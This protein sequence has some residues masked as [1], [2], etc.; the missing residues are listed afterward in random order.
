MSKKTSRLEPEPIHCWVMLTTIFCIG[1]VL[2]IVHLNI[3]SEDVRDV[4]EVVD[5]FISEGES[6][7]LTTT[8]KFKNDELVQQSGLYQ[9]AHYVVF[10]D[11]KGEKYPAD[12]PKSFYNGIKE[13]TAYDAYLYNGDVLLKDFDYE[14]QIEGRYY[15]TNDE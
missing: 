3:H 8:Y 11:E 7:K 9:L 5:T 2:W 6:I 12:V 14:E 15:I 10:E 1:I 4:E 13:N